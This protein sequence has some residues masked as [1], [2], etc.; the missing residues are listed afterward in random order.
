M[1]ESDTSP[2]FQSNRFKCLGCKKIT[3]Q[4]WFNTYANQITSDD[5]FPLRIQGAGLE[6]LSNN[7]QF[8]PEVRKQKVAYWNKVNNGE[9]FLDRWAPVHTDV[10][11]AGME[12]SVCHECLQAAVWLG[13]KLI[14]PEDN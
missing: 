14:Y 7:P 12:V 3:D 11:V 8:S 9:V 13:G 10:F 1:T 6:M 5:G 2:N 4:A